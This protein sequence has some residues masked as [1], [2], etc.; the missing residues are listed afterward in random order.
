[1]T[2]DE[3]PTDS[4]YARWEGGGTLYE[5]IIAAVWGGLLARACWDEG[6][7]NFAWHAAEIGCTPADA[8]RA[9][10]EWRSG[11]FVP[12]EFADLL[13]RFADELQAIT[14]ERHEVF[15]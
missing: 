1:M 11:E 2:T 13:E 9:A 4:P 14:G 6:A 3:K 15:R 8:R 5:E 7:P 12:P 10:Q